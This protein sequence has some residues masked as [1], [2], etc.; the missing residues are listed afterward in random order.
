[1]E[2]DSKFCSIDN[3]TLSSAVLLPYREKKRERNL[4][5][6]AA[7]GDYFYSPKLQFGSGH[8]SYCKPNSTCIFCWVNIKDYRKENLLSRLLRWHTILHFQQKKVLSEQLIKGIKYVVFNSSKPSKRNS[9]YPNVSYVQKHQQLRRQGSSAP[10]IKSQ[11]YTRQW[12]YF[13]LPTLISLAA[14]NN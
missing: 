7:S 1:M 13:F 5:A 2:E 11:C 12:G 3:V 14:I 10:A 8:C 9:R 4:P 6:N